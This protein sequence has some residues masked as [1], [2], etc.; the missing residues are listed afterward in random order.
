M[1]T[2]HYVYGHVDSTGKMFYVGVGFQQPSDRPYFRAHQTRRRG[3][4]WE[5]AAANGFEVQILSELPSRD[6][7]LREERRLIAEHRKTLVNQN[8]GGSAGPLGGKRVQHL[9]YRKNWL[10]ALTLPENAD[11]CRDHLWYMWPPQT[12]EE[13][14]IWEKIPEG[15]RI[16]LVPASR[17]QTLDP[18]VGG[19]S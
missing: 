7:A 8:A 16:A 10:T 11:L 13:S 4:A 15:T 9:R 1:K 3:K 5:S 2:P 18:V 12:L 6:E 14:R 17:G 19:A